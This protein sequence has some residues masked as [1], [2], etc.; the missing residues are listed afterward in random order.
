MLASRVGWL[1][2]VLAMAAA[3]GGSAGT[4]GSSAG[5]GG[6]NAGNGGGNAGTGGG[7]AGTGGMS[8]FTP[9]TPA[10]DVCSMLALA[11]VQTLLPGATGGT[12]LANNDD[13]DLWSRGCEWQTDGPDITLFVDGARTSNGVFLLGFLVEAHSNSNTQATPVSG[14]GDAAVFIDNLN[15]NDQI[16]NARKG[17][18]LVSLAFYPTA[19]KATE[20]SLEPLVIE[21][22]GKL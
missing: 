16:L 22:L 11:D 9:A 12:P 4:G 19:A 6:G 7:N 13:A 17:N 10:A 1:A 8:S 18:Q 3:C 15:L 21:A 5:T 2:L 20:A 14:V